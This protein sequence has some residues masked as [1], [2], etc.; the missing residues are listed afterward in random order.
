MFKIHRCIVSHILSRPSSDVVLL[1][2]LWMLDKCFKWLSGANSTF[3]LREGNAL[4]KHLKMCTLFSGNRMHTKRTQHELWPGR[5]MRACTRKYKYNKH[6]EG[7]LLLMR[8]TWFAS[9][10]ACIILRLERLH[11]QVRARLAISCDNLS[12][13]SS[14]AW[15]AIFKCTT[16]AQIK[17]KSEHITDK[18]NVTWLLKFIDM[19]IN[20][21]KNYIE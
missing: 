1:L 6:P 10:I 7:V 19:H 15:F 13:L 18:I 12:R 17:N 3:F 20:Y 21:D 14:N 9:C 16:W 2:K 11:N 8:L 4:D 5:E